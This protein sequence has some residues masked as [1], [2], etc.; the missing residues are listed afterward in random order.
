MGMDE[1]ESKMKRLYKD[2]KSGKITKEIAEEANEAMH[3]IEK[4]G[5]EAKE[6]FSDMMG[7]MKDSIKRF[8][9]KL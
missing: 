4:L 8:K 5:G 9:E 7:E 2:M 3:G 6:K 1:L